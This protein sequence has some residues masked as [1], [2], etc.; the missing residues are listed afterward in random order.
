MSEIDLHF[1]KKSLEIASRGAGLVSPSAMVGALVVREGRVVGEGFYLYDLKKHAEVHALEMAGSAARGA[2]VYCTL[3][4]CSHFGRTPPCADALIEAG[5]SRAV[6]A[7]V[8]PNPRVNGQGIERLRK[9]GID[10]SVGL[11]SEESKQLNEIYFK[12][13]ATRLP[14][15]HAVLADYSLESLEPWTPSTDF[16]NMAFQYDAIL[17]GERYA[18]A[19]AIIEHWMSRPRHRRL[20]L[21]DVSRSDAK[22]L[23][24]LY[25]SRIEFLDIDDRGVDLA[26]QLSSMGVISL[27]TLLGSRF[28]F[29]LAD[30]VTIAS[31]TSKMWIDLS[32]GFDRREDKTTG[33]FTETTYSKMSDQK[34]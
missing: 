15:I 1:M 17:M 27:L 11:R 30:K 10:V 28:D 34:T 16:L 29:Q 9:A 8:D 21:I 22:E 12:F 4:P 13:Q 3:E 7:V 5:I 24:E 2:T 31:L 26:A 6:V 20:T 23:R 19:R 33:D 18:S 14:F 25:G 32:Y